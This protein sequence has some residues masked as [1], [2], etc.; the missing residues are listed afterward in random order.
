[1][2][3]FL[4]RLFN[5]SKTRI[6]PFLIQSLRLIWLTITLSVAGCAAPYAPVLSDT[7]TKVRMKGSG[8]FL[9]LGGDFR[10][11]DS[12]QCGAAVRLPGIMSYQFAPND[13]YTR[14]GSDADRLNP[15]AAMFDSP[16]PKRLDIVE[17]QIS[18]GRYLFSL[19]AAGARSQCG[20]SP[21]IDLEA[22]RE[23]QIE[24]FND[25]M[26]NRCSASAMRLDP[27]EGRQIWRAYAFSKAAV[28]TN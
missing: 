11:S 1:M 3:S 7:T 4:T 9:A 20:V 17:L 6:D 13:K 19:G 16:D 14:I 18:P 26:S 21:L 24:F 2:T 5:G 22:G 12:A 10:T 15:R 23:Y 8:S 27:V 25:A 28:C